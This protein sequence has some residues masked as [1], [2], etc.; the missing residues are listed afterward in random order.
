MPYY[1]I[2]LRLKR[3]CHLYLRT[4]CFRFW[5]GYVAAPLLNQ[6][7][8]SALISTA[9]PRQSN[10][11]IGYRRAPIRAV[12]DML[13]HHHQHMAKCYESKAVSPANMSIC[14]WHCLR[15]AAAPLIKAPHG[16]RHNSVA[17]TLFL[18][19]C[20]RGNADILVA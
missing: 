20:H 1:N 12:I 5:L 15:L 19:R 11:S 10:G 3:Y 7:R 14:V 9:S 8:Y 18:M 4:K 16:Y 2:I 13:I 6:R 17:L